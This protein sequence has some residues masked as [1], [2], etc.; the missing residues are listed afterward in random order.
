MKIYLD[1]KRKEPDGWVRTYS[2]YE[3]I[4]LLKNNQV[5][6]LSLDHDLGENCG[7]GYNVLL[8]IESRVATSNYIPPR[9]YIHTAN[10][11]ARIKME[12]AVNSINKFLE[13]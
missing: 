4:N 3:T 8:W 10:P 12:L 7:N 9:I 5:K 2:D 6:E 13:I 11:S 1:D